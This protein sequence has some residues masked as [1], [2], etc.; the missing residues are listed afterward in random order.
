MSSHAVE[1]TRVHKSSQEFTR[2]HKSSQEFHF[3]EFPR[4]AHKRSQEFTRVHKSSQ[5]FIRVHKSSQEFPLQFKP[6]GVI[7]YSI[8]DRKS[9]RT[10]R[11]HANV[12]GNT[13]D[14]ICIQLQYLAKRL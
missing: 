14:T 5:E 4:D 10:R 11:L 7:V 6:F 8:K 12:A 3:H 1:F 2:V 9:S 13:R